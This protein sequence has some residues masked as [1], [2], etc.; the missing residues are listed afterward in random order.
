MGGA[1]DDS[2]HGE[3]GDDLLEGGDGDDY[4]D[5]GSGNDTL[6]GGDGKVVRG[7]TFPYDDEKTKVQP[8]RLFFAGTM[9]KKQG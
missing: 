3:A 9:Y 5:G 6:T 2:L 7:I 1:G 4:L 8:D